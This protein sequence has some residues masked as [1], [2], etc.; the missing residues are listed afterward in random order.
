MVHLCISNYLR[1]H[2]GRDHMVFGITTT[3]EIN[4]YHRYSCEIES[5][6]SIQHYVINLDGPSSNLIYT[7]VP[8]KLLLQ[9]KLVVNFNKISSVF[10]NP[11]SLQQIL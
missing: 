6:Y 2:R 4:T 5:V 3:Y 9:E 8:F 11:L 1:G 7:K 10:L